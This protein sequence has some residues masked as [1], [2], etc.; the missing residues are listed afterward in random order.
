MSKFAEVFPPGDF[1]REELEAREWTQTDLAEIMARPQEAVSR[2]ITGKSSITPETAKGLGAAFGTSADYW[3]NLETA[4]QL[5]AVNGDS[6]VARRAKLYEIAP[7][8]E[9]VKR[10]WIEKSRNVEVLEKQVLAFFDISKPSDTPQIKAAARKSS[11]YST[12]TPS[13]MAWFYFAKNFASTLDVEAYN[14]RKLEKAIE[15]LKACTS[16]PKEVRHVPRILAE[17]GVRFVVVKHLSKSKL[18]GAAFWLSEKPKKPVVAVTM[19]FDRIDCFWHTL[20]HE[21]AHI[22]KGDSLSL[23]SEMVGESAEMR[24]AKPECERIADDFASSTLI[25]PAELDDF[26]MRIRPLYSKKAIIGFAHRLGIHPG[27]VVGQ[28]QHRGEIS[29]SHSR[30]MLVKVRSVLVDSALCDGWN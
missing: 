20:L 7:V 6:G 19:R 29:Y 26:I 5:S 2:I 11:S 17:A 25:P 12:T 27:L 21:L 8:S 24:K 14:K 15:D 13:Q 22:V 1:I 3:I 10:G 4:Y 30:E 16:H 18:D 23:D 28:L 9:M